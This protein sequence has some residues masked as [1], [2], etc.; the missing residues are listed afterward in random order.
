MLIV[1]SKIPETMRTWHV[2]SAMILPNSQ[3]ITFQADGHELYIIVDALR[4][5]GIEVTF[6]PAENEPQP[7]APEI[8][9]RPLLRRMLYVPRINYPDEPITR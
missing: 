7:V 6:D 9:K 1:T 4:N 8:N 2:G 3:V 5:R